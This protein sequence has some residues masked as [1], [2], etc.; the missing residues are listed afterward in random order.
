V[1]DCVELH[2]APAEGA[3]LEASGWSLS[4]PAVRQTTPVAARG[5]PLVV[6]APP[7]PG[8][9]APA[10]AGVAAWLRQ[11][12]TRGLMLVP[13]A[14]LDAWGTLL[15][16]LC[17]GTDTRWS[18]IRTASGRGRRL[19]RTPG[20][21]LLVTTAATALRLHTESALDPESLGALVLVWPEQWDHE[22]LLPPL[23]QELPETASR[24]MITSASATAADLAT[25]YFYRAA[26][27]GA[28]PLGGAEST[29]PAV[30]LAAVA[31]QDRAQACA[32]IIEIADPASVVIWTADTTHHAAV[33]SV[34]SA[35][36]LA[37]PGAEGTTASRIIVGDDEPGPTDLVI[38]F[39]LPTREQL[40][41]W[42]PASR[43]VLL[44]PAG[45][46]GWSRRLAPAATP[47]DA[48]TEVSAAL[49]AAL[50]R[51]AEI[52]HILQT[53]DL[54]STLLELA[55]LFEQYG[56][57]RVA[58]A[59]AAARRP[60]LATP[61]SAL[62]PAPATTTRPAGRSGTG[63]PRI[64]IGA[65]RKDEVT[66]NDIVGL[67]TRELGVERSSIGRIELRDTFSLIEFAGDS[68]DLADRIAG[69][70]IRKRRLVA[71][72]DRGAGPPRRPGAPA[73]PGSRDRTHKR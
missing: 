11:G 68:A 54:E 42:T 4:L 49:Q 43:I 58:A 9:A 5:K 8:G 21:H 65:G 16:T 23:L 48:G 57:P 47:L 52:R 41:W 38:G 14:S 20:P 66:A 6:L 28:D 63:E 27:V 53:T 59:L 44:T 17:S 19:S 55:P 22:T 12:G 30:Q 70:S 36:G 73:G 15:D 67:L 18:V 25:R 37:L 56:A 29:L 13:E 64:W 10:L 71:R 46:E 45:T 32:R 72:L 60:S 33:R 7:A 34:L 3:A 50:D 26:T 40:G 62:S 1:S 51:R 31:W 69:K 2:L 39:D 61:A 35:G 24:T